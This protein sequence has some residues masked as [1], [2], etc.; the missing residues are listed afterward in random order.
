M[1]KDKRN[2]E[3]TKANPDSSDLTDPKE[4]WKDGETTP[5]PGKSKIR[6]S[7]MLGRVADAGDI[8]RGASS[9]YG[10]ESQADS[11][12]RQTT[13]KTIGKKSHTDTTR[14]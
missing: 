7:G 4:V 8:G 2:H 6:R 12:G 1:E 9:P 14:K 5:G 11:V 3:R 13:R 10:A